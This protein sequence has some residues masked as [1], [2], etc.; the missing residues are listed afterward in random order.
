MQQQEF[1]PA[2]CQPSDENA[3]IWRYMDFPK[4]AW[5][6]TYRK[7]FVP[8]ISL[9]LHQ[10]PFEGSTTSVRYEK[11]RKQLNETTDNEHK[12]ITNHN[13]RLMQNVSR[14]YSHS[15]YVSCWHM[16]DHE[17]D[18]M[19]KLY[20]RSNDC[21]AVKSTY[22]NLLSIAP[23]YSRVGMVRYIDY[24]KDDFASFNMFDNIMHKRLAFKHEQEVRMVASAFP[25]GVDPIPNARQEGFDIEINFDEFVSEVRVHPLCHTWF[26]NLVA[27]LLRKFADILMIKGCGQLEDGRAGPLLHR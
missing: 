5:M 17:S 21:V 18:A 7:L 24:N 27:E 4:F 20:G 8:H 16:A 14:S 2:F 10:D 1:H 15:Y 25:N 23:P 12:A 22:R 26:C 19:W 9:L 11:M 13:M 3:A 6:L